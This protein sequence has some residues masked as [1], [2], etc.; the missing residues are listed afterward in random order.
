[1]FVVLGAF[2]TIRLALLTLGLLEAGLSESNVAD[3]MGGNVRRL[4]LENLPAI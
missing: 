3:L 2:D 1:L 4:L